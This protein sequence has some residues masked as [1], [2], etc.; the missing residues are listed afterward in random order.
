MAV[1]K[2]I[3]VDPSGDLFR[4]C[5]DAI[6]RI[7]RKSG[8]GLMETAAPVDEIL[9]EVNARYNVSGGPIYKRSDI[10]FALNKALRAGLIY[11][12]ER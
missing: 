2:L 9:E 12:L 5:V 7:G 8:Y 10:A 3:H 1:V 4:E 11:I 6:E